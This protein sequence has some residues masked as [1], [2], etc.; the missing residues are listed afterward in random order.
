MK[1]L[2]DLKI[3]VVD[4]EPDITELIAL[5]FERRN[6]QVQTASSGNEGIEI[7]N[8]VPPDIIITDIKMTDGSGIHLISKAREILKEPPA[9]VFMTAYSEFS[10]ED[11]FEHGAVGVFF[12]PF[13]PSLLV[14]LVQGLKGSILIVDDNELNRDMLSRRLIRRGYRTT[15]IDNG[16]SALKLIRSNSFDLILLD[17]MMPEMS[18]LEVLK[19]IRQRFSSISLP[20]IMA[21]AKNER[22]D[23]IEALSLG[24]N[25]YITKPFDFANVIARIQTQLSLKYAES[26]LQLAKEEALTS[27]KAKSYFLA[28]MSHEIRTPLNGIIGM[29]SLLQTT[30]MT[31]EQSQFVDV[32]R[33]SSESLMTIINDIL[34]F[35]K[36]EA[37]KMELEIIPFSINNLVDEATDSYTDS[38]AKRPNLEVTS[39]ISPKIPEYLLG[40]PGRIRQTIG[41]L[42][43][44]AIKFTERGI[45]QLTIEPVRISSNKTTL[46]F[47]I[48][49]TGIGIEKDVLANLFASFTQAESS[50]TRKFGGTG[51]GLSICKQLVELMEGT[52]EVESEIGKGSIFWF[53]IDLKIDHSS[54]IKPRIEIPQNISIALFSNQEE[55]RKNIIRQFSDWRTDIQTL[56]SAKEGLDFIQ[57]HQVDI[58]IIDDKFSEDGGLSFA[59]KSKEISPKSRILYLLSPYLALT[60]TR[61]KIHEHHIDNIIRKPIKPNLLKSSILNLGCDYNQLIE[62]DELVVRPED[63]ISIGQSLL[64]LVA[65]DNIAN[66]IVATKMIKKCGHLCDVAANGKEAVD[67][68]KAVNYSFA[69]MDCQ[70]PEMDGF[71]AAQEIREWESESGSGKHLPIIAM[72]ANALQGD[73]EKCLAS[74]MDDYI[75]KPVK[76]ENIKSAIEKWGIHHS[77]RKKR[78]I[79]DIKILDS[80]HDLDNS[81]P[82]FLDQ[83][84]LSFHSYLKERLSNIE[85]QQGQVLTDSTRQQL[86]EI[87]ECAISIGAKEMKTTSQ[88]ILGELGPLTH[89]SFKELNESY[90]NVSEFLSNYL[91]KNSNKA[92]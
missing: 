20:V 72:T 67:A 56:S 12:K 23:I 11:L 39:Y 54:L 58:L 60:T 26:E 35:S 63:T 79:I 38:L 85:S 16:R 62:R 74:G 78:E 40:D 92:S 46:K 47:S 2:R 15:T 34:D 1:R 32:I 29:T 30:T 24:A 55:I 44:N 66:Q 61:E 89:R 10:E 53:T 41:N 90:Q 81:S 43:S 64:I 48:S 57:S 87:R 5:E 13:N 65:E 37:G 69:F 84:V 83:H 88:K 42:L 22:S 19:R 52:I 14:S 50:T 82:G 86:S 49:D 73:K 27:A 28:S 80:L 68:I 21:T 76:L 91:K 8:K 9:F 7:I 77:Q 18:G 36:I 4:D 3:L 17:I 25:D 59:K 75:S 6:C 45:V 70:M 51:L 71:Q 31:T 33:S